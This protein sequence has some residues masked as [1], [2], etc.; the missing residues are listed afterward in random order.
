M[1][2]DAKISSE[3]KRDMELVRRMVESK[4][5]RSEYADLFT[6]DR[7]IEI[8]KKLRNSDY[9]V[10]KG[11]N[12][13]EE[14]F[15]STQ[16]YLK[17]MNY[18]DAIKNNGSDIKI[19]VISDLHLGSKF[20]EPIFAE[21][22]WDLC[23]ELGIKHILDLGDIAEGSE[24]ITDGC[25]NLDE[26]KIDGRIESQIEYL[27][28]YVPYDKDISHHLLYGNHDLYSSDGVSIDVIRLLREQY[29]RNDISICGVENATFPIN[30]DF[31]HLFHC[32]FPDIIKPYFKRVDGSE[33]NEIM[34]AGHSHI[35]KSYSG[36]A[37]DLECIPTLSK[38][39]HHLEGFEFYSGFVLL[40]ISFDS[41]LKMNHIFLQRYRFDSIYTKP[42]CFHSH[43]IAVRRLTKN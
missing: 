12:D 26:Y 30:N 42:A 2:R 31:I 43:E 9:R 25:K 18:V 13:F 1:R 22:T 7:L 35:S 15:V 8:L 29:H 6:D 5:P 37:F 10:F 11:T 39:N 28:K 33:E 27:N 16:E 17:Q 23:K 40:T 3:D 41:N 32:S 24:Y 36:H 20:D 34:L 14:T 4:C 38:V 21:K 19:C